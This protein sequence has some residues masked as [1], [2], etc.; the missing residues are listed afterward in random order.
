MALNAATLSEE[1][2]TKLDTAFGAVTHEGGDAQRAQFCDAIAQAVV[3]HL[4]A[5][6]V[7]STTVTGTTSDGKTVSGTGTGTIS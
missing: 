4:T 1:I 2:K 3:D 6:G 7:I 5:N